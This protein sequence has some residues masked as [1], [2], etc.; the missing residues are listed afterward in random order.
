MQ[1]NS[2]NLDTLRLAVQPASFEIDS[3][4][5]RQSFRNAMSRLAAGVNIVTT[6]GLAGRAGFAATAICSVTDT[7]PTLL[8]CLNRN[9][10]AFAAVNGNR[11]LCVNVLDD[12][13]ADLCRL[14]GGGTPLTQR[15]SSGAWGVGDG[16]CP[17]L[18]GA[19]ASFDCRITSMTS[20][21]THVVLLCEVNTVITHE[22]GSALIYF[23]RGYHTL[24]ACQTDTSSS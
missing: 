10:S 24:A 1:K 20:C 23:A 4:T 19:L 17:R 7:P 3:I 9:S 16:G 6:D 5:R 11:T 13:H 21:G 2:A 14:F 22:G 15:F 8:V 12:S 18:D